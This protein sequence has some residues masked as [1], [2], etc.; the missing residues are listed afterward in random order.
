MKKPAVLLTGLLLATL[1]QA[2]DL[3]TFFTTGDTVTYLGIDYSH[4]KV[5]GNFSQFM[6]AGE[7]DAGQLRDTY[8]PA[9][10]KLVIDERKK[11]DFAAML[12]KE[13]I[14]YDIAD[15]TAINAQTAVDK[16][17]SLN[18]IH[19]KPDEIRDFVAKYNLKGKKGYGFLF[20]AEYLDKSEK[21]AAFCF[22][23]IGMP[24]GEILLCESI[25]GKPSGFGIRNYWAGALYDV[26]KQIRDGYYYRWR[27]K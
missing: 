6:G 19:Y 17:E 25:L 7:K 5:I 12:Q 24:K 15:I 2:Q 18:K 10:N 26:I 20:I 13:N 9:W 11:Y 4:V 3:K 8:F 27:P 21:E 23:V 22:V 16:I 14:L 1:L